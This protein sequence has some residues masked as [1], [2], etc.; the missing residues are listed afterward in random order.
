[1][2]QRLSSQPFPSAVNYVLISVFSSITFLEGNGILIIQHLG[3]EDMSSF[4]KIYERKNPQ[5]WENDLN[6]SK[7]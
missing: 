2:S 1:M 5:D 3:M 7:N 4:Y 6:V